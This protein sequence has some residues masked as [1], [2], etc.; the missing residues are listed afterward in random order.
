MNTHEVPKGPTK[1][2]IDHPSCDLR[3]GK[4]AVLPVSLAKIRGEMKG[5]SGNGGRNPTMVRCR[6]WEG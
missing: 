3:V 1:P 5:G 6:G 4:P 2:P